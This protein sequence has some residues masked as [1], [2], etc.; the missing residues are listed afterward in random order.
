MAETNNLSYEHGARLLLHKLV[1]ERVVYYDR[2]RRSWEFR[3]GLIPQE[4]MDKW[5]E[6]IARG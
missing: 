3:S 4:R 1:S 6:E 5:L 2:V